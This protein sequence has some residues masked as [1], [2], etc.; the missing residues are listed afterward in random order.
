MFRL[1]MLLAASGLLLCFFEVSFAPTL[2]LNDDER[3]L[4]QELVNSALAEV[5]IKAVPISVAGIVIVPRLF[6]GGRSRRG[7]RGRP[8]NDF[9]SFC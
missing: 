3:D 2:I 5:L 4:L 6:R 8:P 9:D 1:L 7:M